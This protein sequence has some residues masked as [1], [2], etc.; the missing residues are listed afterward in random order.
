MA[1]AKKI[2][3]DIAINNGFDL[4]TRSYQEHA[5]GQ[6]NFAR[7]SVLYSRGFAEDLSEIFFN[8][9]SAYL[10]VLREKGVTSLI[11]K[12]GKELWILITGNNKLYGDIIIKTCQFFLGHLKLADPRNIDLVIIGRQGKNFVDEARMNWPYQYMEIPD[13]KVN[14]EFLKSLLNKMRPY[15]S[16]F[17]FYGKYTNLVSQVPV[18]AALSGKIDLS[19]DKGKTDA[20]AKKQRFLYEPS[21]KEII[22]FF[23]NQILS[24]LLNQTVQEAQLARFASRINAMEIAQN[25][26]HTELIKLKKREKLLKTKAM[27]KKQTELLS[28]RGLWNRK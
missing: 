17:V 10:K 5:V 27:N 8:V 19:S 7:Y 18:Q 6:I 9:K 20:E 26:I 22:E 16:I 23:E 12:N 1:E 24:L 4:L 21:I 11:E 3:E 15:E 13:S 25:N 2:Q 28:G 14:I